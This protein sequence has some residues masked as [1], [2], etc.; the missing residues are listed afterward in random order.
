LSDRR[1]YYDLSDICHS[2]VVCTIGNERRSADARGR[3]CGC[4][5]PPL[6]AR[7]TG[8]R[9]SLFVTTGSYGPFIQISSQ[10][11]FL[12]KSPPT[13][14]F[15]RYRTRILNSMRHDEWW[16]I[17]MAYNWSF[18]KQEQHAEAQVTN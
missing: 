6:L 17:V 18:E 10:S 8:W 3:A 2:R 16:G 9:Y 15:A 11:V 4:T 7:V 14:P 12:W 13:I 5:G 1:L